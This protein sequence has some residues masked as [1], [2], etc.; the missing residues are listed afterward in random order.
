M[1]QQPGKQLAI[2][3]YR[4]EHDFFEEWVYNDA[5]ID[6]AKVVWAHESDPADAQ[7]LTEYF[8]DRKVWLIDADAAPATAA[9]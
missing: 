8:H 9:P 3:H 6:A 1:Q 4:P 5:S 7:E 2:V